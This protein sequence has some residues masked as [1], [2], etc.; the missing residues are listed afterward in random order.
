[1]SRKK[2]I[3]KKTTLSINE[4]LSGWLEFRSRD[5][6][7]GAGEYLCHLAEIDR[8]MVLAEDQETAEKYRM[9]LRATGY[10]SELEKVT[11]INA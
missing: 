9:F 1:M 4:G 3:E 7:R 2:Q 10:E 6:E 11:S 5:Y 8:D